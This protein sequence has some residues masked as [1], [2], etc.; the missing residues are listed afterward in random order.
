MSTSHS[1]GITWP[2]LYTFLTTRAGCTEVSWTPGTHV[3]LRQPNG[4]EFGTC[5]PE[6][7]GY[8][9]LAHFVEVANAFGK[10]ANDLYV[11]M[12]K[13]PP[14]KSKLT[15]KRTEATKLPVPPPPVCITDVVIK[16]RRD[17][18]EILQATHSTP[19]QKASLERLLI[20]TGRWLKIQRKLQR[21]NGSK[22][23]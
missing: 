18:D 1:T 11:W 7:P 3:T 15:R 20:H 16:F 8:V 2:E 5:K 17:A 4:R 12:G 10:N 9:S 19:D 23:A 6:K 14:G 22:V 13:R 21:R